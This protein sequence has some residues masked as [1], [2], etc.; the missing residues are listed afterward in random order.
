MS[1]SLGKA[2]FLVNLTM[3][4]VIGALAA[5][6]VPQ[7]WRGILVAGL[8]VTVTFGSLLVKALKHY[9]EYRAACPV[10]S[11]ALRPKAPKRSDRHRQ[12]EGLQVVY[13]NSGGGGRRVIR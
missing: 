6:Q 13:S 9:L 2:L 3:L 5:H 12:F 8:F 7:P 1:N 10:Q 4:G 11:T